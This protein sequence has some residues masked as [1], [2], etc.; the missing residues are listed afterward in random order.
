LLPVPESTQRGKF[1]KL[2]FLSVRQCKEADQFSI[3]YVP[4]NA[5][6]PLAQIIILGQK[7]MSSEHIEKIP[8]R[9]ILLL[10]QRARPLSWLA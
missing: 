6:K 10:A 8:V 1:N 4:S 5:P 7:T 9:N 3:V 2:V